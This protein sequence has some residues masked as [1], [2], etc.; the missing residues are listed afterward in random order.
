MDPVQALEEIASLL[1]LEL[2]SPF[3]AK[4]FR[5]AAAAIDGVPVDEL[6]SRAADG[7]LKRTP[8]IGDSSYT[9]IAEALAGDVPA[10]LAD[11]RKKVGAEAVRTGL[12][13][14]SSVASQGRTAR[15]QVG[16]PARHIEARRMSRRASR[17]DS[18]EL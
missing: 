8:G 1:E 6:R 14:Q 18:G 2:A 10:Y 7:R 9:V 17:Y 13:A 3:K 12:R 4:A 15:T 5:K 11:L 16:R